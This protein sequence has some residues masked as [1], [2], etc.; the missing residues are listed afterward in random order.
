M[1]EVQ[2]SQAV[3]V[4]LVIGAIGSGL[5]LDELQRIRQLRLTRLAT[6]CIAISGSNDLCQR[7]FIAPDSPSKRL[8]TGSNRPVIK[9]EQCLGRDGCG[10]A[11]LDPLHPVR[12]V[13]EDERG[14]ELTPLD[15]EVNRAPLHVRVK[16][17]RAE[18]LA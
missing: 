13:K 8:G 15:E 17:A 14:N 4:R 2:Q 1:A 16:R 10:S 11:L 18:H 3:S 7:F 5:F 12:A 9:Q 6:E